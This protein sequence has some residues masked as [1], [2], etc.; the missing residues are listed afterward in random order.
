MIAQVASAATK[1]H[2]NKQTN[3]GRM[4]VQPSGQRKNRNIFCIITIFQVFF[5]FILFIF[6]LLKKVLHC[7]LKKTLIAL[8][9][10]KTEL[11]V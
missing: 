9:L 10:R 6:G 7:E 2:S 1:Q 3:E 8:Q 5:Y 4:P 11:F